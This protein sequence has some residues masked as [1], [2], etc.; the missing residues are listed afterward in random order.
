M[1]LLISPIGF[2]VYIYCVWYPLKLFYTSVV[3]FICQVQ[4]AFLN[5][6]YFLKTGGHYMLYVQVWFSIISWCILLIIFVLELFVNHVTDECKWQ[7]NCKESTKR[8]D[9]VF[10]SL[11]KKNQVQFKRMEQ[12]TLEPFDRDHVYVSGIFRTLEVSVWFMT[13]FDKAGLVAT[14]SLRIWLI[15]QSCLIITKIKLVLY[16]H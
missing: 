3:V 7:G 8:G 12:V 10:S 15:I 6:M 4:M 9:G 1:T 2:C 13:Q 11:P 14:I 5:A 16:G